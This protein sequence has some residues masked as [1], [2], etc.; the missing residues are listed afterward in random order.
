MAWIVAGG[1]AMAILVNFQETYIILLPT[2]G[3]AAIS[4]GWLDAAERRRAIERYAVFVFV[5]CIGLLFYAGF[6]SFRFGSFLHSGKGVNHPSPIG[7][8]LV[9][10]PGLLVSPGKSIFLYSPPTAIALIGLYRLLLSHRVLGLAVVTSILA[11]GAMISMLSFYGGDW[12]WG[13]R[14][15]ATTLPLTAL[16]FPFATFSRAYARLAVRALVVA[17]VCVQLLGLSLDH[18]RFFYARSLPA[19]FWY[20]NN[21][22][23]FQESALFARPGEIVDSIQHGVPPEA[24]LFRPGPYSNRLTYAVFG[25]WGHP[26]LTPPLWMR[27][28][29]VFW[30]P[31]PWPLWMSAVPEEQLPIDLRTA[32][33][34]LFAMALAGAWAIRSGLRP[35][36]TDVRV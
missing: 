21:S 36:E 25:G 33:A 2:I 29:R 32:N 14:Y 18:H 16:G 9:G 28:Y 30:L 11:H 10:L 8:P 24:D 3:L 13:P 34:I 22:F 35:K 4:G 12:C 20:G 5:G 7:N 23:Y 19:F 26:E 1:A 15:F 27:H 31:R 17:G 6:N